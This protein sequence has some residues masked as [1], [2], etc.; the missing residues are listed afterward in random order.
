MTQTRSVLQD[1]VM[2]LPLAMQGT[3]LLALRGPDNAPKEC[4]AKDLTRAY[5]A[6]IM[7][8][9]HEK[10]TQGDDFMGDHSGLPIERGQPEDGITERFRHNHDQ[11]PHHWLMHLVHGAQIV[12]EYCP[13]PRVREFW[14]EF[15]ITMCHAFHMDPERP[16]SLEFRLRSHKKTEVKI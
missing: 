15:Y 5:R 13:N 14:H 7:V 3:L 11:Y 16:T 10:G 2:K 12:G 8:N 1:W 6:S 9:A 4:L